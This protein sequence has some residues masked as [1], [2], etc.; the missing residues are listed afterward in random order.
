MLDRSTPYS[1]GGQSL[2][3]G[4]IRDEKKGEGV[5]C[6]L[7]SQV[8]TGS[9]TGRPARQGTKGGK[10]RKRMGGKRHVG[11][12]FRGDASKGGK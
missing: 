12:H 9:T 10:G 11:G 4:R 8:E 2:R 6:R 5:P 7:G 3:K 1:R